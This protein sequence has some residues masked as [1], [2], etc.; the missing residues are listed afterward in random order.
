MTD[1]SKD[2]TNKQINLQCSCMTKTKTLPP[3]EQ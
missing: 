2:T 1:R 3:Y